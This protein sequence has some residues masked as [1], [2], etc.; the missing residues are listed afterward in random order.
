[1]CESPRDLNGSENRVRDTKE[2]DRERGREREREL[3]N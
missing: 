1:M 2:R 3:L